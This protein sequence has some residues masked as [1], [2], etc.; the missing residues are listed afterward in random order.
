[1]SNQ[2]SANRYAKALLDV[3]IKEADPVLAETDLAAFATLFAT[4]D[5]L[6]RALTNPVVPAQAKRTVVE[7]LVARLTPSPPVAKLML[8]L[9]ERDRLEILPDLLTAYRNRLMDH[10]NVVRAEV[11]TAAPLAEDRVATVRQKLAA[12]TGRTVRLDARVDPSIVGGLVA[13]VG[14]VVYDGSIATH[15]AKMRAR[16]SENR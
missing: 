1:M 9:A 8:L 6:R 16:L 2:A 4:H 5:D 10:Q 15:L 13:R 7:Q 12:I 14:T 11:V 3:A